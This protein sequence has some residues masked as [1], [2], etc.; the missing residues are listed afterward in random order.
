VRAA[1]DERRPALYARW[2]SP[3]Q[4]Q[5]ARAGRADAPGG[6]PRETL[7]LLSDPAEIV[8]APRSLG[9]RSP[10]EIGDQHENPNGTRGK[11][12]GHG[13]ANG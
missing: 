1:N 9:S 2:S 6:L 4:E 13:R 3:W 10:K 12:D 7:Q 8:V 11:L 5:L